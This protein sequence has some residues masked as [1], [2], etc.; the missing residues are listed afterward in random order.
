MTKLRRFLDSLTR[1]PH[2]ARAENLTR[3]IAN[4]EGV[5]P[6]KDLQPRHRA[7]VAGVINNIRIDPREG[8]GSIEAT[9]IDGTGQM[10]AKWLGRQA[11]QGITLGMG[12]IVEGVIGQDPTG[13]PLV[14]NPEYDLVPGPEHGIGH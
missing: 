2:E 4:I 14:L 10:L 12:I 6:I 3:W 13:E 11:L 9:F 1:S 5:T 7:R 8:S